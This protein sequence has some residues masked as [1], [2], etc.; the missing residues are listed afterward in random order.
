MDLQGAVK[1]CFRVQVMGLLDCQLLFTTEAIP[2]MLSGQK[3]SEDP[4]L[5]L[6]CWGSHFL[7]LN[8]S[9]NDRLQV[10]DF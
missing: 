8:F 5:S 6:D 3:W 4:L 7:S 10:S 1:K 9:Y 2:K